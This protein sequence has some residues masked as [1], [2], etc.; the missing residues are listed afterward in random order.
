[1]IAKNYYNINWKEVNIKPY[2]PLQYEVL[3][4]FRAGIK[5][6]VLKKQYELT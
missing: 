5:N 3:K 6:L 2:L 4:A 1:M